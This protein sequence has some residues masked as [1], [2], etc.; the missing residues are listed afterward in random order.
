MQSNVAST[1]VKESKAKLW[2]GRIMAGL[3]ILTLLFD[4]MGKITKAA[5]VMK[6]ITEVGYP[7]SSIVPIGITL[8]V[9]TFLFAIPRTSILGAILLTGYLGGAVATNVR[10]GFP[11]FSYV[12]VPVYV[13]ILIWGSLYLLEPRVRA[14]LP[15]R[16]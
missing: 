5:A 8:L 13:G 9:C 11:L 7:V 2:A 4:S 14:I 6:G 16:S 15:F 10:A 1:V 12:L 3:V